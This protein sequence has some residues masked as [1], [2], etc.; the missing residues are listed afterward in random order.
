MNKQQFLQELAEKIDCLSQEDIKHW[1]DYYSEMIDDMVEDGMTEEQAVYSLGSVYDVATQAMMDTPMRTIVKTRID[2]KYRLSGFA[3]LLIILGAVV[4]VPLLFTAVVTV[5]SLFIAFWA[6]II[7]LIA[8]AVAVG[9]AGVCLIV[10]AVFSAP[11][12]AAALGLVGAGLVLLGLSA[13][14]SLGF[15]SLFKG[16]V[17]LCKA[18]WGRIKLMVAGRKENKA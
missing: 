18:L 1:V 16:S 8:A 12:F 2:K 15:K 5:G 13:L 17:R 4:W 6:V 10:S 3:L 9:I 11:G 14:A 7:A